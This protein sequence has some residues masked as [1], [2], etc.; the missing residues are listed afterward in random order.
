V[1][2]K[3]DAAFGNRVDGDCLITTLPLVAPLRQQKTD[4]LCPMQ[5]I[6]GA[7]FFLARWFACDG[8]LACARPHA[9]T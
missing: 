5:F 8:A 9:R 1:E 7:G 4:V 6:A 3:P 2:T